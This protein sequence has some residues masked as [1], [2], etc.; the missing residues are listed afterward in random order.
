VD[1]SDAAVACYFDLKRQKTKV[2]AKRGRKRSMEGPL[3]SI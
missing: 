1:V 2:K 3:S